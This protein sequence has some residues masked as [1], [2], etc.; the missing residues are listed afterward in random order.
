MQRPPT[1]VGA[2]HGARAVGASVVRLA[3]VRDAHGGFLFSRGAIPRRSLMSGTRPTEP[4]PPGVFGD[5]HPHE[6]LPPH[7]IYGGWWPWRR[8]GMNWEH[9]EEL[10]DGARADVARVI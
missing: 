7:E 6:R 2:P 4:A 8:E 5:N 10:Q 9:L 1:N 3:D